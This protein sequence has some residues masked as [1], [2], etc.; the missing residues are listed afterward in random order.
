[1]GMGSESVENKVSIQ[2][3]ANKDLAHPGIG[4]IPLRSQNR[5]QLACQ[6]RRHK[7][8]STTTRLPAIVDPTPDTELRIRIPI[9]I[10]TPTPT[11][12]SPAFSLFRV[13]KCWQ[14]NFAAHLGE[15]QLPLPNQQLSDVCKCNQISSS[16]N[17][18]AALG[19]VTAL[20]DSC[21]DR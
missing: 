21:P 11:P 18:A 7:A 12:Y 5:P 4:P 20:P 13:P 10:P 17:S 6:H 1:M 16:T 14:E 9:P 3:A 2:L 15:K 19:V 8:K